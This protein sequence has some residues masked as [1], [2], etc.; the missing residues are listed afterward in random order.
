MNR[1]LFLSDFKRLRRAYPPEDLPEI[2]ADYVK[3]MPLMPAHWPGNTRHP[4]KI[5]R[6]CCI[7]FRTNLKKM[8]MRCR[9]ES[10]RYPRQATIYLL[11]K[12]SGLRH[13]EIGAIFGLDRTTIISSRDRIQNLIDTNEDIRAELWRLNA[14][15]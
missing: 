6:H 9:K 12:R 1:D 13:E 5:I 2:L 15:L 8:A 3:N 14:K 7:Y 4:D 11:E 10:I